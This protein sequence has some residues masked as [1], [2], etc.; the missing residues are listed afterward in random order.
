MVKE[1]FTVTKISALTCQKA[2]ELVSI[3]N[4]FPCKILIGTEAH[5][6]SAK[7]LLGLLTLD[8]HQDAQLILTAEGPEEDAACAALLSHLA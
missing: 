3:A 8:I 4:S 2:A 5:M 6:L 7:S 1:T